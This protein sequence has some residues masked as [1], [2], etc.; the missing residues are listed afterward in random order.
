M[1]VRVKPVTLWR[2]EVN[3]EPGALA[4]T[5]EPLAN[6][7]ADLQIVMGYRLPDDPNRAAIEIAPVAGQRATAAA[8]SAGLS[9]SH[10]PALHVEGDNRAGLGHAIASALAGAQINMDFL[11]AVVVGGRHSTVIGFETEDDARRAVP[12]VKQAAAP[13]RR[14]ASGAATRKTAGGRTRK[15]VRARGAAGSRKRSR[16][17][18]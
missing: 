12:L 4:Q 8:Q 15:G 18:V 1:A 13:G 17:R 7:R 14:A 11:M 2:V 3:N 5:L 9:E 10:I 6:A 16:A